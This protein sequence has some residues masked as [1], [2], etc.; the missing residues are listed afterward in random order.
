MSRIK[1]L[2]GVAL[3]TLIATIGALVVAA[4]P[5]QADLVCR[6][7]PYVSGG[8]NIDVCISN[9][10]SECPAG[11]ACYE[12]VSGFGHIYARPSACS[13]VRVYIVDENNTPRFSTS[14][15][16][17]VVASVKPVEVWDGQFGNGLVKARLV[18]YNSS[19]TQIRSI[20]SAWVYALG[21]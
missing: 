16:P 6:T 17:C 3:A 11:Q 15:R 13:T 5:A 20:D 18:A 2:F 1:K 7:P 9:Q 8:W 14:A 4:S 19:G 12:T 10:T 21:D